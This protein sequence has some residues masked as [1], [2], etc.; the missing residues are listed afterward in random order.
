MH[1]EKV[2][3]FILDLLQQVPSV[4]VPGLG[5]FDAIFHPAVID[6]QTSQIKPPHIQADFI[7]DVDSEIDILPAY[8]H[9]V[10]GIDINEAKENIHLFVNDVLFQ[11]ETGEPY[12][13][14]KFGTFSKSYAD[15][16]HFTP[17]WDAFNLS[18]SGLEVI[19]L[20]PE[21]PKDS[22]PV[23][24]KPV[25]VVPEI[26]EHTYSEEKTETTEVSIIAPQVEATKIIKSPVEE[27]LPETLEATNTPV[28]PDI[29]ESTTRLAWG[30]LASSLIL[31]TVLCAYLAWD[32]IS[33]RQRINERTQLHPDT[34]SI[35]NEF[36]IP[37]EMDTVIAHTPPEAEKPP[38]EKPDTIEKPVVQE[39]TEPPCF[40][41]VGAFTNQENVSKMMDRL[42]GLGYKSEKIAGG[43]LT[44]VAISTSCE[45]DNLQKVLSEARASINPEAWIY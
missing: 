34:L 26:V 9:Y 17:D 21:K 3:Y 36:D 33:D 22:I 5:R 4:F 13:I 25:S 41:V 45:K 12:S 32:I 1:S 14:D 39:S 30:I 18:F 29:I 11:L 23:Y 2:P 42:R 40:I 8:M 15:V 7:N 24:Q 27:L 37:V 6:L 44:R 31:I 35:T 43:T 19:D 38:V 10:S 20:Y 28:L 16:L